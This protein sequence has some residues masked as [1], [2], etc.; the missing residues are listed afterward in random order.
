MSATK[1]RLAII[2]S[3]GIP[4]RYGGFETFVEELAPLLV[5]RGWDVTVYCR[6]RGT[7]SAHTYRGVHLVS[8]PYLRSRSL[9]TLSHEATAFLHALRH[10]P[11]VYYVLGTRA[12]LVAPLARLTGR[13]VVMH[14][15][16]MEWA[17]RKWGR[18]A[19]WFLKTSEWWA[20]HGMATQLIADAQAMADYYFKRYGV[21]PTVI[22]YGAATAA[23]P[24]VAVLER[25]GLVAGT[26]DIVVC[27]LE[28]ENNVDR[29]IK[30]H[31]A[32]NLPN[33]LII[34][35]GTDYDG[36]YQSRL[37]SVEEPGR[38][39]FLGPVYEDVDH[40]YAGALR[41]LHGHE[42]G[43]MNPSLLRAMGAGAACFALDTPF[44]RET[45]G[46]TGVLWPR[47][48]G[49]L[50][51][52]LVGSDRDELNRLSAMA[53]TRIASTF[54]WHACADRHDAVFRNGKRGKNR[55]QVRT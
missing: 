24:D 52:A 49:A 54:T 18:L 36:P 51:E 48:D 47:A 15:D 41:Y 50:Q 37:R 42:V 38:V 21:S 46:G 30:E 25:F 28:P 14:T 5:E 13:P 19:Q 31:R 55:Q 33:E 32:A 3:K 2:G 9:E 26:Y 35:G 45:L 17:R 53:R 10:P 20:A 22:P 16:G 40:L 12:A 1:P 27:R 11:D 23:A 44:N 6:K 4:A 34:V 43:G 8:T 29:I 7:A 39:R